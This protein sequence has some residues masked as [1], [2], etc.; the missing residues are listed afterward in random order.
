MLRSCLVT[1]LF[2]YSATTFGTTYAPN[3][4]INVQ[5]FKKAIF[6]V[7][8][9]NAD[10]VY[11]SNSKFDIEQTAAYYDRNRT[12]IFPDEDNLVFIKVY[13]QHGKN[14]V[15]SQH[16]YDCKAGV[17]NRAYMYFDEKGKLLKITPDSFSNFKT[18]IFK[19]V[20]EQD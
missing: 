16:A 3:I 17:V 19:A 8:E 4:S 10:L 5:E 12:K 7:S 1:G 18:S 9:K 13:S 20:C 14:Y 11:L 2:L 6:N 15:Y